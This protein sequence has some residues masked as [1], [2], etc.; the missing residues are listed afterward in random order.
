VFDE[1]WVGHM[2]TFPPLA[3]WKETFDVPD[4]EI[5]LP[6][7]FI[8]IFVQSTACEFMILEYVSLTGK[9]SSFYK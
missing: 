9:W 5:L 3:L 8:L 2:L 1:E 4:L 7:T 6:D